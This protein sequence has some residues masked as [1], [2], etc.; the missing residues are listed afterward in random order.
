MLKSFLLLLIFEPSAGQTALHHMEFAS[1]QSCEA[2]K[3][4]IQSKAKQTR[5]GAPVPAESAKGDNKATCLEK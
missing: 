2:A 1:R 5:P 4:L 3:V